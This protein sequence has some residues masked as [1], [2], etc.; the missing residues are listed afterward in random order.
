MR[1]EAEAA[2][3]D[4]PQQAPESRPAKV[5]QPALPGQSQELARILRLRVPVI[6]QLARRQISLGRIRQLSTGSI[7]EFEQSVNTPLDLLIRN[8]AIAQGDAV[9]VGENFGMRITS[10]LTKQQRIQSLARP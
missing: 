1:A 4:A 10:V 3:A 8:R 6:V 5:G 9:K 2:P 7:I